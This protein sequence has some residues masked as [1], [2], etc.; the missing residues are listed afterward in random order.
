MVFAKQKLTPKPRL[1]TFI[2]HGAHPW[3]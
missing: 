1:F 2:Y 3:L